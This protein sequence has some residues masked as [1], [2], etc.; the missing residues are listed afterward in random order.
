LRLGA[1]AIYRSLAKPVKKP[2]KFTARAGKITICRLT[3]TPRMS[4][5]EASSHTDAP[6]F[7]VVIPCFNEQDNIVTL[8]DE[9]RTACGAEDYEIVVVDDASSDGTVAR[10]EDAQ[11]RCGSRLRLVRHTRNGGQSA[12]ICTG[13]DRARGR[14]IVTLDGDG[15]N[16]PADIPRLL[17]ALTSAPD[18]AALIVCGHRQRRRDTRVRR[19]SSR[20]ANAVRAAALGDATPDTGCGLKAFTRA[21]FLRLPRFNHMHRFLPALVQRE[22]GRAVSVAVNHRPRLHGQSKYGIGNRLWVGIVDLFGVR[23][24]QR[25]G[26]RQCAPSGPG[27]EP[28]TR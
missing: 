5:P 14:Y 21:L 24:L 13:V 10:L 1:A 9:V 8:V 22:H 11:T 4:N 6:R 20:I 23:W 18:A 3:A 16:D 2:T 26:L 12:A 28:A 27:E 15:Q 17:D 19:W 25:R 7:S